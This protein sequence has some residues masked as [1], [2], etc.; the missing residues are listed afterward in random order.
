MMPHLPALQ[1]VLPLLA[2]PVCVLLGHGR[3]AYGFTL[4]ISWLAFAISVLLLNSVLEGGSISYQLGGWAPPW[5]IELRVDPVNAYVLMIVSAIGAMVMTYARPSVDREIRAEREYLYYTAHLLC[6]AGLLGVTITGDA[7][8]IFV[9]F[10]ISS[11]A[12]YILISLGSNRRALV[13]AF[14]YLVFGT[15]GATFF[16]IGVGMLYQ[17]TGTLNLADLAERVPPLTGNRTV[18]AGFIFMAIGLALKA[19]LFPLH[20]WL[21]NAYAYAPSVATAFLAATATKVAIYVLIRIYFTVFGADFSFG[22]MSLGALLQILAVAAMIVASLIAIFQNDIKRMLAYSSV[23]QVGYILLGIGFATV[24]GL[25]GGLLHLFNHA[26]MKAALFMALGCV[27]YRMG[28]V[29]LE[30]M[31]G[32]GSRMPW[33]T[34]S[35]VAGGLSLIGVP[36]TVGFVSKWYLLLATVDSGSWWIVIFVLASSLLAIIYIW[37]VVEVAYFSPSPEGAPKGEAPLTMLIP[38][39]MLIVAN[40]YFGIDT[41]VSVGVATRAAEF[42]LGGGL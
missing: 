5:G 26:L 36:M 16:L 21:P 17:M 22:V 8:N 25:T 19:A 27:F 31:A 12:S 15:I 38:T 6:L 37:R 11:L 20:A 35:F 2:A 42:L 9:F 1:I 28:S 32:I 29:R 3:F 24:T 7:F 14:N 13:A 18:Q 34:A 40:V 33:T 10:E 30:A 41:R 4:V 23:A 39:W